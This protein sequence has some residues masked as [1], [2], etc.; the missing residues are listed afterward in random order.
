MTQRL[1]VTG[2]AGFI[3]SHVTEMLLRLGH[4]VVIL[5]NFDPFYD[6]LI[7]RRNLLAAAQHSN[8]LV[9]EGDIRDP[10]AVARAFG[11][12]KYA[13]VIHLAGKAGVRPSI[14]EPMSYHDVNVSGTLRLLEAVRATP[15][16]HFVLGS[17]SSVYGATSPLP[18][19][20]GAPADRPSSPYAATKRS[21]EM[22]AFTYH[23]LY[24]LPVT[25]LRFFTVYGPRQRPEMA[26]HSFTRK[27]ACGEPLY[28]YGDGASRRDYT[29]VDDIVDGIRRALKEPDGYRLYNLGTRAT[30]GLADLVTQLGDRLDRS[31]V[32]HYM[33]EQPGDV[34]ITRADISRAEAELGFEARTQISVGLDRFVAWYQEVQSDMAPS[35]GV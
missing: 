32:I 3:G 15:E 27:I 8:C 29:Y 9:V 11:V 6:P 17:S 13:A 23:H 7:K 34:P 4:E 28:I 19:S 30:T 5:D 31:P 22:L 16:T 12:G 35:A 14:S 20:E 25:T 1:L 24:S 18:F 33:P 21:A 26:I 10:L 2:G